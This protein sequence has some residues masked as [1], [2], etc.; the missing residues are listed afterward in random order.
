MNTP[1]AEVDIDDVLVAGLLREQHP[2]LAGLPIRLVANGWDNALYRLG[3]D[4]SV[5]LPRREAAAR[6]IGNEARWLPRLAE[7]ITVRVPVPVRVGRPSGDY[8][9]AWAV[10]PWFAGTLVADMVPAER[11]GLAADLAEFLTELHVPAPPDA[12]ENP[13]RGVPLAARDAAVRERLAADVLP[14]SAEL[15]KLWDELVGTPAWA[16]APVWV[17]GDLHPSNLLADA[18]ADASSGRLAAVLDFG[19]LTG[20]DPATDL[21]AAWMVFDEG[22]RSVFREH[23][24]RLGGVDGDTWA[25]AR[26]WALNVGSAIAQF[27]ADS[28]RMAAIGDHTLRQVLLG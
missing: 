6:L 1:E 14:C 19:D 7:R 2:D 3:T 15:Q 26:G 11:I 5:R 28:P 9:W 10:N 27:S 22:G 12:P 16:A 13:V 20:G 23:A 17:H 8:P 24:T 4:L 21:A 18:D 25:R